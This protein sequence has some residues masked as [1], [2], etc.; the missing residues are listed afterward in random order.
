M[1]IFLQGQRG[2]GLHLPLQKAI[3]GRLNRWS[4]RK[5][6]NIVDYKARL[7]GLNVKYIEADYTSSLCPICGEKLSPNGYRQMKCS[8]C[9]L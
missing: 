3:N 2:L 1:Q 7:V 4:F 8:E 6:Q 9:E 5:F